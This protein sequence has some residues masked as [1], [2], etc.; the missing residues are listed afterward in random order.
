[1]LLFLIFLLPVVI[2]GIFILR[3]VTSLTRLELILPAG[4][5]L[6]LTI[7]TFLLNSTAFFVKGPLG[8]L[9]SYFLTASMGLVATKTLDKGDS[10]ITVPIGKEFIFWILSII[11][12]SGFV[13]WKGAYALIGSDTNLYYSIAHSFIR[14]NFPILTP[15]QPDLP[16]SYHF[17]V[18]ELL[19]AFYYLTNLNFIFLHISFSCF[20]IICSI[21]IIFWY[22]ERVRSLWDFF[23][24]NL[25]VAVLFI[26]FG[27]FYLVLPTHT[28]TIPKIKSLNE[29][30]VSLRELPTVNQ[31]IE[32][33]GA[34]I[35]LD[36][37]IYFA[38]HTFGIAIFLTV[39]LLFINRKKKL[40]AFNWIFVAICLSALALINESIFIVAVIPYVFIVVL[41]EFKNKTFS[42]NIIALLLTGLLTLVIVLVQGGTI[43][44]TI[45]HP[46]NITKSV[47]LF[48]SKSDIKEDF[49]SYHYFQEVS[50]VLDQDRFFSLTWVH[51]GV[52]FLILVSIIILALFRFQ[53]K[54]YL[55]ILFLFLSG[56]F[57]LLAYNFVVPRFLIANGNRF[58][59]F[60][61]FT[62]ALLI[63]LSLFKIVGLEKKGNLFGK[64]F[65]VALILLI[66]LP[67]ILPPLA[68]LSKTRFGENKLI[69][70]SQEISDGMRWIKNNLPYNDTVM[71]LDSRTP[72]PSGVARLLVGSG[73]FAPIFPGEF[74]A[75]TIEASPEYFDIAYYLSPNALRKLKIAIILV[76]KTFFQTLPEIRKR[77]L[78]NGQYFKVLFDN[79]N[80]EKEWEKIY[81]IKEDYLQMG[82]EI[83]GSFEQI[84]RIFSEKVRVYIDNEDNFD[85]TYLRRA[86]IFSLRSNQLYF[87]PQSGVYLNVEVDINQNTPGYDVNYDFLVLGKNKDPKE[88]CHCEVTLIWK[89]LRGEVNVWKNNLANSKNKP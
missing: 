70:R 7:F 50:K 76:D 40:R 29:L 20:F 9:I 24:R 39:A 75:Y 86:I 5:I 45:F 83:D 84:A 79:S 2:S 49:A 57:S 36:G 80:L 3:K 62:L 14:G 67:T 74:R 61:F 32:V 17:G 88:V 6:G 19:G 46:K 30:V 73:V 66:F 64:L 89:G 71:V 8:V 52:D 58:L 65:L 35:N 15:W 12:W 78:T 13:L 4:V 68:L 51:L 48:P 69:P 47:E 59:S 53:F 63:C 87:E 41:T 44:M 26:S 10:K 16:L 18:F 82:G 33:Y 28:L 34:P 55:F 31:S 21:Q 77:Q 25:I 27:F 72:H 22:R 23:F 38:F 1:M 11:F 56:L 54:Q 60:S 42:K 43:T 81:R 37:L 85:P